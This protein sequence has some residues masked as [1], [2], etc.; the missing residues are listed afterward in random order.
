M[1]G[2]ETL[3][4]ENNGLD[5]MVV[6]SVGGYGLPADTVGVRADGG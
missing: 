6:D 5:G 1:G 3:G 2:R 4:R